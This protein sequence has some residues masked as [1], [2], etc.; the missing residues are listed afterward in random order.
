M[1][2][3]KSENLANVF[4]SDGAVNRFLKS[5][6]SNCGSTIVMKYSYFIL[7]SLILTFQAFTEVSI[8]NRDLNLIVRADGVIKNIL[9]EQKKIKGNH[10]KLGS[11]FSV[12]MA[13]NTHGFEGGERREVALQPVPMEDGQ[14]LLKPKGKELPAFTLKAIDKECYFVLKITS[15]KNTKHEHAIEFIMTNLQSQQIDWLPL[16]SVTKKTYRRGGHARFCGVQ[17][18]NEVNP[19]GSIAMW[20]KRADKDND[21]VLY[22]IWTSENIPHPKVD[23]K[24]TIERAK[25]WNA[26]YVRL[27]RD[28][29][30]NMMYIGPRKP[31]DLKPIIGVATKFGIGK[32]YMH[33]NTWGA[34][35]WAYDRDNLDV[36]RTIFP[37]GKNSMV[38]FADELYKNNMTLT[39]RTTS[40]AIGAEHP[41]Y[42][43]K[44][45][46]DPRLA[47]WWHGTLTQGIDA[48]ATQITVSEGKEHYT[49]HDPNRGQH[50]L[51]D[52]KCMQIG[53]ELVLYES[54]IDNNNG[55]WTLME[56]QRG[57]GRTDATAHVPGELA[58]GL[59]RIY[60]V[61]FAPDPD[62]SLLEEMAKDF[63]TFH[64]DVKAGNL[65]FDALEVHGMKTYYGDIKF[66]G[67]AYRHVDHPV[68]ADTS[69][70]QLSW[71][72]YEPLF[73]SVRS[74]GKSKDIPV[75]KGIPYAHDMKIGLHQ[76]HWSASS[77]YAYVWAIP[78]NA[79]AGRGIDITAQAGFHDLTMD[80]VHS[81]G[82]ID[83]YVKVF[84]QWDYL[85]PRLPQHIKQRIY[86][87]WMPKSRYSWIDEVFRFEGEG[88]SF[89][90]VPFR[91]MKREGKDRSWTFHQEH[92]TLYP[93][94]YIRPGDTLKVGNPYAAQTPEFIIRV[95]PDFSRDVSS[96]R[97]TERVE[98]EEEKAFHDML[99]KFQG[100]SG[101]VLEK[102]ALKKRTDEEVSY[103]IMPEPELVENAGITSF[104]KEKNGVRIR[105]TNKSER[106][107][108][109]V[110]ERGDELP[111]YKV[112]TDITKAGGL[113]VVVT[114][115]GSGAVLVIRISGQGTRD[116]VVHLDFKGKRY[117]EIPTPQASWADA[118]WPFFDAFKR[119]R[120]NRISKISLGIDRIQPGASASVLLEDLRL[121]PEKG[122]ALVDPVI[123]VGAGQLSIRGSIASD[124]YLWYQGGANVGVYD[125]NWNKIEDL[126][127]SS[128]DALASSPEAEITIQNNNKRGN[129]WLEVQ[130]YVQDSPM[131]VGAITH[132]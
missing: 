83:H 76:S 84:R 127:V 27:V 97:S 6:E 15:M 102:R 41:K 100:A 46:I 34:R 60:G 90:V 77:P 86:A 55:T 20:S 30:K 79:T 114:G 67:A 23:G 95:M 44:G 47:S 35:Y 121:L 32:L 131:P 118:R 116:Y 85:G 36:N 59:Y 37:E 113:G 98:S 26:D 38:D 88:D 33:L 66:T 123:K 3:S 128:H 16:D 52:R 39:F 73:E 91:V 124:R 19:L 1:L 48:K 61:A 68:L 45:K 63:A 94:Q 104:K 126:P 78:S 110:K 81:H 92:G 106:T 12:I 14:I 72:F 8:G 10:S 62:S 101:V 53:N 69:G 122:S 31:E 56:C 29:Y 74:G 57:F 93:Y 109:L 65:N 112:E 105:A 80:M 89:S 24:W 7:L 111:F 99:D 50:S 11:L 64:N 115:D 58:K 40:Y 43:S 13:K 17:Q 132:D 51:Y 22:K 87:S 4:R 96:M 82:L 125:L 108:E 5:H 25:Q 54:Y 103:L 129:P 119:W 21:E 120:G 71:G 130:F 28:G 75:P 70:T 2:T 49:D 117:I 18:R 9:S 42:L 107:L